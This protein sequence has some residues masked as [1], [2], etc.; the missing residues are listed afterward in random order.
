M[1]LLSVLYV[2]LYY[3]RGTNAIVRLALVW[4]F[5]GLE[6][7]IFEASVVTDHAV[8]TQGGFV[9]DHTVLQIC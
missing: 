2:S 9:C 4:Y 6:F 3:T 7:G 1:S 5:S 8:V